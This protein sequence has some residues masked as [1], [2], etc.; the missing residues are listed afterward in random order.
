MRG[1]V[2][3]FLKKGSYSPEIRHIFQVKNDQQQAQKRT[4]GD[5]LAEMMKK[6]LKV[7]VE[8]YALGGHEYCEKQEWEDIQ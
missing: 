8:K 1:A 3:S 6:M 4:V 2:I 7:C 5:H